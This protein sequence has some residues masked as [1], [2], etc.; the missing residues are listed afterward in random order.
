MEVFYWSWIGVGGWLLVILAAGVFLA[1][2]M[3]VIV[4]IEHDSMLPTLEHGDRV[5]VFRYWPV[6]W[7]RRGSIVLV[8]PWHTVS[9]GAPAT[10][11]PDVNYGFPFVKRV[12]GLPGDT[13]IMDLDQDR[14]R[15]RFRVAAGSSEPGDTQRPSEST[16]QDR[17]RRRVMRIPPGHFYVCGDNPHNSVDSRTWGPLPFQSLQGVAF[18][19]LPR[20]HTV[21]QHSRRDPVTTTKKEVC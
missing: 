2:I 18:A 19:R 14:D 6:Q 8:W 9:G 11:V 1:R 10:D 17:N 15:P 20:K 12:V 3:L 21:V 7:L 13:I 5:V 16:A 4:T